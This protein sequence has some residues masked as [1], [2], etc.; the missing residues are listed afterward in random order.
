PLGKPRQRTST[1]AGPTASGG[2]AVRISSSRSPIQSRN[3]WVPPNVSVAGTV[4]IGATLTA[5]PAFSGGVHRTVTRTAPAVSPHLSRRRAP[6][7]PQG[8][9]PFERRDNNVSK[10]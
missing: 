4:L 2:G 3:R 1:I 10:N 7:L 5:D 9:N 6:L 8:R